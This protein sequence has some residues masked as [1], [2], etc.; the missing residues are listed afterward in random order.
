MRSN[1][2][3]PIDGVTLGAQYPTGFSLTTSSVTPVGTNFLLGRLAPGAAK[4]VTL[5]GVLTGQDGDERVFHFTVGTAKSANDPSLAVTYMSQEAAVSITAPFLATAVTINGS[6]AATPAIAPGATVVATVSWTNTLSVPVTNAAV[7]VMLAGTALDPGSVQTQK[8]FYRS[9]DRTLI[10]NR[11]TD[12]SLASLAPGASGPGTFT[13]ATVPNAP[14]NSSITLTL[15]IAGERIGQAGVPEQV[16]ASSAKT[17]RVVSAVIF[18]A[19]ALHASGP[20]TN[21][22]AVPPIANQATAYAIEWS[23]VNAGNDL[24]DGVVAATLPS[25]VTFS[26]LTLPADSSISYDAPS[27]TVTWK[28]GDIAAGSSRQ[29]TFQVILTPST[30]QRGSA[31]ALTGV[32]TLKAFDRF[33]QT[34]ISTQ[35]QVATTETPRDPG[36]TSS[37]A[38]VQ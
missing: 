27:R 13:F 28:T 11:D 7:E 22:G 17:L 3:T 9:V 18:G 12:P 19:A 29:A 15:S 10:F 8:G 37:K 25:Y 38:T 21:A 26:G 36:Y 34:Q 35:G 14:R 20:F 23:L 5:T 30:T 2:T 16:L 24:A 6:S 32:P 33:A 1:A 31:P 4:T